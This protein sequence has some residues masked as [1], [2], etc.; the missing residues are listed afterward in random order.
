MCAV[1]GKGLDGGTTFNRKFAASPSASGETS[2]SQDGRAG[3]SRGRL[4]SAYSGIR[5]TLCFRSAVAG[6]SPWKRPVQTKAP[7]N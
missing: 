4:L 6:L 7:G 2:W 3:R 1:R 5:R